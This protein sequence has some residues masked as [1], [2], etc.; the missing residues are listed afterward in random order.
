MKYSNIEEIENLISELVEKRN[1]SKDKNNDLVFSLEDNKELKRLR[2]SLCQRKNY[3]RKTKRL[4]E[5]EKKEKKRKQNKKY[6]ENKKLYTK[7]LEHK[8]NKLE[9]QIKNYKIV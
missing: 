6:Y 5:E 7:A 8:I 9:N 2:C 4:S 3:I 1:L